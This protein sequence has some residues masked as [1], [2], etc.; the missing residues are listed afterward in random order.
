MGGSNFKRKGWK[1]LL[2][3]TEKRKR[4]AAKR[5]GVGKE[6]A[7]GNPRVWRLGGVGPDLGYSLA[8]SKT[9]VFFFFCKTIL[10]NNFRK[11]RRTYR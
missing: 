11:R 9:F 4:V 6:K 10:A 7:R 1:G 2:A 5:Q 8:H 3:K